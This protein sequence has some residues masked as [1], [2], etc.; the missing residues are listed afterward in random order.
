QR[1][2]RALRPRARPR[3]ARQPLG[4]P[5]RALAPH[6]ARR[7]ARARD[8]VVRQSVA[9]ADLLRLGSVARVEV[10]LDFFLAFEAR[11]AGEHPAL[12]EVLGGE[13]VVH[14]HL[15]LA[16]AELR[17]AAAAVALLAGERGLQSGALGG[18]EQR[19]A[20]CDRDRVPGLL[21]R[22]DEARRDGARGLRGGR[23]LGGAGGRGGRGGGRARWG[24]G[25]GAPPP[26]PAPPPAGPDNARA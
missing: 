9:E 20:R 12:G 18:G 2:R 8:D 6:G 5:R 16:A 22:A 26:P 3:R 23:L 24:W 4:A 11:L 17:H 13:R 14:A 10:D 1:A 25:A 7:A 21:E 19:L 15:H